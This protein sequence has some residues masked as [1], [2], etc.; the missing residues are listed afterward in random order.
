MKVYLACLI[1]LVFITT[2]FAS[3]CPKDEF[4]NKLSSIGFKDTSS[5]TQAAEELIKHAKNQED[6]C[7]EELLFIF[8]Q[9]YLNCLRKYNDTI[10][11]LGINETNENKM[12]KSLFTIGWC[13]KSTEGS[14]YIG[15]S[16]GWFGTKFQEVL[17][18]PYK[19]YLHFRSK[20]IREGFSEDAGLLISW[21]QL[22]YRIITWES[23]L[24][25]YPTFPEKQSIQA[26]LDIYI[27]VFLSGMDNSRIHDCQDM[28]LDKDVRAA[29]EKFIRENK[30]SKYYELVKDY[31]EMIKRNNFIVPK[32]VDEYLKNKGY[33][34][35]LATQPPTY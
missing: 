14:Y 25:K 18:E 13:V 10:D 2:S 31:Y 15:E 29:Y 17:T 27:R 24:N 1:M 5:V 21:D 6:K 26:Y 11:S 33:K 23:F 35:Y 20:E 7:R 28:T 32:N 8:R 16:A 12:N 9:Y 19:E 3:P 34:S 22:R 30:A 4:K